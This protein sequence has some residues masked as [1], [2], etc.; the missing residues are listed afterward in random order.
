MNRL[1]TL[2]CTGAVS[3]QDA[4]RRGYARQGLSGSGAMDA[5]ALATANTLVGNPDGTVAIEFGLGGGRFRQ[6]G[7]DA[8]M[9]LAGAPCAIRIDGVAVPDHRAFAL[10]A[11]AT[12]AIEAPRRGVFAY[13]ARASGFEVPEVL[14]SRALHRRAG[15]GGIDG[16]GLRAGDVLTGRD[17][18]EAQPLSI[19][20]L[21]LHTDA[22]VRVVLGPQADH[23]TPEAVA[24]LAEA[25]FTMS[26]RADR[27]GLQLDGPALAHGPGG[28]NIVSDATVMG[29]VQVPG[30]GRPIVL[31][32]DRQTTGGYPKIATVISVDLRRIAQ[33]RPGEAVR[34]QPIPLEEAFALARERAT[35]LAEL[36]RTV[37]V[38]GVALTDRLAGANLAGDA[39]DALS[40]EA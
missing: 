23:F 40:V 33:R 15:L 1:V 19:A 25:T 6:E 13:L 22:P 14:G 30:G 7:G 31:M 38:H 32:A 37:C 10:R 16:H 26:H 18:P 12:L 24:L 3:L 9:A 29:S 20:P 5:L 39:V 28:Y 34:F 35:L 11:G 36:S 2:A 21:P 27:M 4:G 17:M 8:W